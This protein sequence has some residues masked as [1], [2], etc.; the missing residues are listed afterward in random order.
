MK[1][2]DVRKTTTTAIMYPYSNMRK[3]VFNSILPITDGKGGN[4][5]KLKM[6]LWA[7]QRWEGRQL[8]KKCAVKFSVTDT[9]IQRRERRKKESKR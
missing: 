9:L 2:R 1:V 3:P 5:F 6:N 4:M 7:N 8:W